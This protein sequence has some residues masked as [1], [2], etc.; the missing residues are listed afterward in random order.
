MYRFEVSGMTCGHCISTITD[1]VKGVDS[2]A[3]VTATPGSGE[4][5]VVSQL[6]AATLART[7]E[8]AGYPVQRQESVA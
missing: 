8:D 3:I 5:R 7:I 1:A 2:T 6:D 4:V